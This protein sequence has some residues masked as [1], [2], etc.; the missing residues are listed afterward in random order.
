MHV[1]SSKSPDRKNIARILNS[2]YHRYVNVNKSECFQIQNKII[3]NEY[4]GN[5]M[6]N[7]FRIVE[8]QLYII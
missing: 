8:N 7:M 5:N 4:R 2:A 1:S 3:K 6:F